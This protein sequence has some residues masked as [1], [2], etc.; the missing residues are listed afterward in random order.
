V[1]AEVESVYVPLVDPQ[2]VPELLHT[3]AKD[4]LF[5]TNCTESTVPP[6]TPETAAVKIVD[7]PF[8]TEAL[9]GVRLT[10]QAFGAGVGLGVGAAGTSIVDVSVQT[11]AVPL[12]V[13]LAVIVA[14]PAP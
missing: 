6:V 2:G 7:A 1:Y 12:I 10:V 13:T 3:V 5:V 14:D 11:L 8:A 9:A 4:V